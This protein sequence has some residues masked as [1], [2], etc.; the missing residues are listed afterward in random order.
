MGPC[1]AMIIAFGLDYYTCLELMYFS[2]YEL[3]LPSLENAHYLYVLCP[4]YGSS[5][6]LS[7]WCLQ[8]MASQCIGTSLF[9]EP[10]HFA[11]ILTILETSIY[12][13]IFVSVS[14]LMGKYL[15]WALILPFP[16]ADNIKEWSKIIK[17][18]PVHLRRFYKQKFRLQLSEE[19][20]SLLLPAVASSLPWNTPWWWL[21]TFTWWDSPY[22][23][24]HSFLCR[25][26]I[27]EIL[28]YFY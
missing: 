1:L 21:G 26:T 6:Y 10:L 7:T 12:L 28:H 9:L 23:I 24:S 16:S 17:W 13:P 14:L 20:D 25:C 15:R 3:W 19:C 2:G 18:I 27:L 5:L 22:F 8:E 11:C 4:D